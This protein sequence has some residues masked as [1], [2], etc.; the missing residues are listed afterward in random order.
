[1]IRR[2]NVD[3]DS[4]SGGKACPNLQEEEECNT[5]DCPV[6]CLVD[7]KWSP[8]SKCSK[9]CGGGKKTRTRKIIRPAQN[10]G[11]ECDNV[12][13]Y[14]NCNVHKCEIDCEVEDWGMWGKCSK[15]CGTGKQTRT[16]GIKRP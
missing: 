16:R 12:I 4:E 10:G 7:S 11:E 13:E 6:N 5:E 9:T 1:M 14:A 15:E 2:R 8:W 3:I